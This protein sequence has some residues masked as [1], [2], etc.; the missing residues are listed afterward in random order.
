MKKLIFI[1]LIFFSSSVLSKEINWNK[2]DN[3]TLSDFL[4][5]NRWELID[6]RHT[7][8]DDVNIIY[9]FHSRS[10]NALAICIIHIFE[11]LF[12]MP[13]NTKCYLEDKMLN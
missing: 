8:I 5:D 13:R 7:E 4:T 12:D 2:M 3:A 6:K 10:Q 1:S 9:T 11:N